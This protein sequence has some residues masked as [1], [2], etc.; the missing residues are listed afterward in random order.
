MGWTNTWGPARQ[1][2]ADR[3]AAALRR[4]HYHGALDGDGNPLD[5]AGTTAWTFNVGGRPAD[6]KVNRENLD[7]LAED[8]IDAAE[9]GGGFLRAADD[10]LDDPAVAW[11]RGYRWD[12]S[13]N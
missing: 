1:R 10:G 4:I 7:W 6:P 12:R 8:A 2:E 13:S 9:M 3:R 5:G 11:P